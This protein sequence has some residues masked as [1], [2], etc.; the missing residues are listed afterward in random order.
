MVSDS[1][2]AQLEAL[3]RGIEQNTEHAP[4]CYWSR[5]T[6]TF[7]DVSRTWVGGVCTCGRVQAEQARTVERMLT[8]AIDSSIGWIHL[9]EEAQ[10]NA[11]TF[12][13]RAALR[14]GEEHQ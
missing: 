12:A 4:D 13:R 8:A 10:G 14:A 3:L 7:D 2:Q 5:K 6:P 9:E 11:R 1:V